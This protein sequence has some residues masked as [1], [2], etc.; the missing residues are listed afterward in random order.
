MFQ[1][2]VTLFGDALLFVGKAL[3]VAVLPFIVSLFIFFIYFHIK[4]YRRKQRQIMPTYSERNL[5][6]K[7]Y[8]QLPRR[9]ALDFYTSDPDRYYDTGIH[10]FEGPQGCGKTI[11]LVEYVKRQCAKNP[12][13]KFAANFDVEGQSCVIE[14]I[15]D[16]INTN[17][18]IYGQL[19]AIDEVQN[20]FNSTESREVPVEFVGEMCQQRKQS[21]AIIGTTQRFNRMC[22]QLR[23]ETSFLYRPM[24]FFRAFTVV[25]K[26]R[27]DVDSDGNIKKL[28]LVDFYSFVHTDELRDSY[29][30]YAKVKRLSLKGFVP[31][32]QQ[33]T[34]D[35]SSHVTFVAPSFGV[36]KNQ[37]KN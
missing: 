11:A 15:N 12:M 19:N 34:G 13:A 3:V 25:R 5:L 29:D 31:R 27:P 30:T 18:G 10:I 8:L 16:I 24:T 20:W 22:K 28:K 7:I 36:N 6:S 9:M 2:I 14:D 26:Y 37:P 17:N 23:Q 33:L 4:G 21:K 35:N 1:T 32:P